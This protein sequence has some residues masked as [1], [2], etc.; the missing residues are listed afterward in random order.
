MGLSSY[1]R[2]LL[3]RSFRLFVRQAVADDPTAEPPAL[4]AE[5]LNCGSGGGS[6]DFFGLRV[7]S[8]F[9]ILVGSLFGALF[10]VLAKRTKWLS[11]RIPNSL[12]DFAKYFGSGVIVSI[13]SLTISYPVCIDIY[14]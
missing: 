3:K 2:M 11:S 10:P 8:I 9:I 4:D 14:T 6:D 13:Q 12:F 7:A 1:D 5:E